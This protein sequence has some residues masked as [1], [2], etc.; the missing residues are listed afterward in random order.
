MPRAG[1]RTLMQSGEVLGIGSIAELG[2][3]G[4]DSTP[5][6]ALILAAI[7]ITSGFFAS[8]WRTSERSL[9]AR[10]APGAGNTGAPRS[11]SPS[12]R[13]RALTADLTRR[14]P[15]RPADRHWA[16]RALIAS[17]WCRRWPGP[18]APAAASASC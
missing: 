9:H 5:P 12:D 14:R 6:S 3:P 4:I 7:V 17:A 13:R 18:G 16:N 15:A 2:V 11:R 10:A 8:S 1:L